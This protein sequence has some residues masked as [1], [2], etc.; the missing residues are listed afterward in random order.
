MFPVN[1]LTDL[2]HVSIYSTRKQ[3]RF[4]DRSCLSTTMSDD[5]RAA[6]AARAKALVRLSHSEGLQLTFPSFSSTKRGSKRNLVLFR[7]QVLAPGRH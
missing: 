1:K 7:T 2:N 5:D 4:R 6:K 3:T